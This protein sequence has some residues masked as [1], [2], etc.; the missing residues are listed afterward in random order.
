MGAVM[1]TDRP[2]VS[3][4]LPVY[5]GEAFLAQ[6]IDSILAQSFADF[7]LIVADNA[8]TDATPVIAQSY[9]ARDSRV[10]YDRS[11]R[12]LGAAWNFNRAF[13]MSRGVYFKWHAAD[14]LLEP[15][16]LERCVAALDAD[17]QVVLAFSRTRVVDASGTTVEHYHCPLRSD[18]PQTHIRFRD[19]AA[20]P[21]RCYEVFGLIRRAALEPTK[22]IDSFVGSDRVLLARLALVGRFADIPE[23][24]FISRRHAGQSVKIKFRI[25]AAWFDSTKSNQVVLPQWQNLIELARQVA[26]VTLPPLER[27]R[28]YTHLLYYVRTNK[29]WARLIYDL[30]Y[31]GRQAVVLATM[32]ALRRFRAGHS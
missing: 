7:E 18:D 27:A 12:N 9:A 30:I 14:D 24:L 13:A 3:I 6:A 8:S 32:P 31:A 11:E 16:F 10:R 1:S 25:R 22:L 2:R 4:A 15:T 19:V 28:C 20:I 26:A 21:H 23:A 5:N 29:N 17:P